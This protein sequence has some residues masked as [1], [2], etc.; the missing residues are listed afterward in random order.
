[1]TTFSKLKL[2][3]P[4]VRRY[5]YHIVAAVLALL[6]GYGLLDLEDTAAWLAV[7]GAVLGVGGLELAAKNTPEREE[8]EDEGAL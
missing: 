4:K 1:M 7:A 3:D 5:L 8:P 2:E 6:A